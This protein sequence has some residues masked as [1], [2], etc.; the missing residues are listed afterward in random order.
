MGAQM[1]LRPAS[2]VCLTFLVSAT[3]FA[4]RDPQLLETLESATITTEKLS[5]NLYVLYGVGGNILASIGD[6]GVLIVDN[7]FREMVPRYRATI[8]ELG[9]GDIDFAINTHWHFDHAEGNNVLGPDG[10]ALVAQSNSRQMMMRANVINVVAY[11]RQQPAYSGA[12]LPAITFDDR[13]QLHFNGEQIDLVHFGPAHTTGDAAVIFRGSNVVHMGDVFNTSGYPF[14]DAG[15]GGSI[16]GLI[17]FCEAVLREVDEGTIILPGHGQPGDYADLEDYVEMLRTVR[18]RVAALI[19]DGAT[20]EE[21]IAA[22]PT[23]E[24][25]DQW[26]GSLRLL[27]RAYLSLSP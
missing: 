19:A 22:N 18:E 9:G 21:V 4:Q 23:A 1:N 27:D 7:Q 24:W 12:A 2:V 3:A 13:M 17:L 8:N 11:Q 25:D 16:D 5:E 20:L 14:I 6:Q 10:T 26:S 15:N